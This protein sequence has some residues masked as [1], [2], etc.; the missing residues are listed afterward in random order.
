[1]GTR[2]KGAF[3]RLRRALL[4]FEQRAL[5]VVS[6]AA[7]FGSDAD[8]PVEDFFVEERAHQ[9]LVGAVAQRLGFVV[10]GGGVL[11]SVAGAFF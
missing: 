9:F 7:G 8:L 10:H 11:A 3:Y 6:L 5:G 1:M 4:A 2:W